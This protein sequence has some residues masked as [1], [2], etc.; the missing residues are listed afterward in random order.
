MKDRVREDA[1]ELYCL[2]NISA[3]HNPRDFSPSK[4]ELHSQ[5]AFGKNNPLESYTVLPVISQNAVIVW[6]SDYLSKYDNKPTAFAKAFPCGETTLSMSS[7]LAQV[8][9]SALKLLLFDHIT[10]NDPEE[11][12]K[13]I[14]NK[15][16][17]R[18]ACH[19][20]HYDMDLSA[21]QQYCGG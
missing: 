20:I 17:M 7:N 6:K 13:I 14:T 5:K 11:E 1:P 12:K 9:L 19:P 18:D 4:V 2:Q 8:D 15:K 10:Y 21:V 16:V 3:K